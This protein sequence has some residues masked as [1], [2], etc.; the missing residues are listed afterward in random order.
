MTRPSAA[1][2]LAFAL[3]AALSGCVEPHPFIVEGDA[4]SVSVTYSGD[5]ANALPL[6]RQHCAQFERVP[7]LVDPGVDTAEFD[8]VRR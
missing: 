7:Q 3:G 5:V 6:A 4:K 1:V 2:A 8:C